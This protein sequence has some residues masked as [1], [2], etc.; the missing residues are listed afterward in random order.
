M[1]DFTTNHNPVRSSFRQAAP[2]HEHISLPSSKARQRSASRQ[3]VTCMG[4]QLVLLA[5]VNLLGLMTAQAAEVKTAF[6]T[7]HYKDKEELKDFN[8]RVG[9]ARA[10][11]TCLSNTA[12]PEASTGLLISKIVKRI[13]TI[14]D[15]RPHELN[16]HIHLL[17]STEAVQASYLKLYGKKVDYIAFY[18]PRKETIYVAASSL[19]RSVLVHEIAH[20]I[21]DQYFYKAPPVKIHELLAQYVE[22]RL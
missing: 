11:K 21:V 4:L 15:I 18:S 14:L 20:A 19:K 17:P 1:E 8:R 10:E 12:F 13:E 9:C 3:I 22:N 7:I 16:F 6:A 2:V 5:T